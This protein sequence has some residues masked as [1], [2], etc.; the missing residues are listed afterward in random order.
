MLDALPI[1]VVLIL[2][3]TTEIKLGQFI[4]LQKDFFFFFNGVI[5]VNFTFS[6]VLYGVNMFPHLVPGVY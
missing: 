1:F 6:F 4:R 2:A 3:L 5:G